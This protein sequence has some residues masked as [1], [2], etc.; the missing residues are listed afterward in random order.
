MFE[1][2]LVP[3]DGSAFAET[4]VP[5]VTYLPVKSALL[6][7]V[8]PDLPM[9]GGELAGFG[10]EEGHRAEEDSDEAALDRSAQPLRAAGIPV[11][12]RVIFS[13]HADEALLAA[14]AA[15]GF[16]LVIMTTHGRG[17]AGRALHGSTADRIA[18]HATVPVL[19]IRPDAHPQ[20]PARV[21][22][23]TDGS[24]VAETALPVAAAI[25]RERGLPLHLIQVL[26]MN[27]VLREIRE[28][29]PDRRRQPA[30][31]AWNVAREEAEAAASARLQA[32]LAPLAA[33]GVTTAVTVTTGSAAQALVDWLQPNDLT[34][35]TTHGETGLRRW[36][37]GSV[38][39][40]VVRNAASPVLLVRLPEWQ[41]G[42]PGSF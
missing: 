27:Q 40:K 22:M 25:A 2:A 19:L 7:R 12:T 42:G 20:P 5:W 16:D 11:E 21:V 8:E 36:L 28:N 24:A 17:A 32:L 1:R 35:M 39:D 18:R 26:D 9:A 34:V 14:A 15:D 3:L 6:A 4:A 23:A 33:E 31:D 30:D 38:A 10:Y 37:I 41:G 29:N 13:D